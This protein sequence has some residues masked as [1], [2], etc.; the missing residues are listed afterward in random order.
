M[1]NRFQQNEQKEGKFR[2]VS[3]SY[4]WI[5]YT[6]FTNVVKWHVSQ[7]LSQPALLLRPA[8][9][10]DWDT[11]LVLN[12]RSS[13]VSSLLVACR[14]SGCQGRLCR[15]CD[16]ASARTA[17]SHVLSLFFL[18]LVLPHPDSMPNTRVRH[19]TT[20]D[21]VLIQRVAGTQETEPD[22]S[23]GWWRDNDDPSTSPPTRAGPDSPSCASSTPCAD[24][25][26]CAC[27]T[28]STISP[29]S[30]SLVP[31]PISPPSSGFVTCTISA[32]PTGFVTRPVAPSHSRPVACATEHSHPYTTCARV[33]AYDCSG[34]CL[35][36]H[37]NHLH[38][39]SCTDATP[40]IRLRYSTRHLVFHLDQLWQGI[41]ERYEGLHL[42]FHLR[43]VLMVLSSAQGTA[44][45]GTSF[46]TV[47][48]EV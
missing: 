35:R 5:N 46:S 37:T 11:P 28:T 4:Y 30:S 44:N 16:S 20:D 42:A 8:A 41:D 40:S 43:A 38:S 48:C 31:C 1:M 23:S 25:P 7:I 21:V 14:G 6:M 29:P 45:G 3:C 15:G 10:A 36:L 34:R 32:P 22:P 13:L 9:V 24:T 26:P 2:A 19:L 33:S 18:T 12:S 27:P 39:Q 17:S 47:T